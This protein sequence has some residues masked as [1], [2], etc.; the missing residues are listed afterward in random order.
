MDKQT[1]M[2]HTV[3]TKGSALKGQKKSVRTAKTQVQERRETRSGCISLP[4]LTNLMRYPRNTPC[5]Y[6]SFPLTCPT[7]GKTLAKYKNQVRDLPKP[8]IHET[9]LQSTFARIGCTHRAVV[10]PGCDSAVRFCGQNE[11]QLDLKH[12]MHLPLDVTEEPQRG[13]NDPEC[14]RLPSISY[15]TQVSSSVRA[16][17]KSRPRQSHRH[18]GSPGS[19]RKCLGRLC[20]FS[21]VDRVTCSSAQHRPRNRTQ[22]ILDQLSMETAR[23]P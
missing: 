20:S 5:P 10:N 22:K 19:T 3:R 11:H 16:L 17:T 12:F 21:L 6:P 9:P 18:L 4:C 13:R 8:T 7:R 1:L 2:R 15:P 23:A 14:L